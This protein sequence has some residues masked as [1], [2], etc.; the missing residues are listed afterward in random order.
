[1]RAIQVTIA[2]VLIV[3]A[4]A[5]IG[6]LGWSSYQHAQTPVALS[7]PVT[8]A[9]PS[10]ANSAAGAI[11]EA[12]TTPASPASPSPSAAA[13]AEISPT[14][15]VSQAIAP[16]IPAEPTG[17]SAG[18][19]QMAERTVD[20]PEADL[21]VRTGDINNLGFGWPAGFTPFSGKST[22]PHPYPCNPRPGAPAGTDRIMVGTAVTDKDRSTRNSD[23]YVG[24][25]KRPDDLPEAISLAVGDLPPTVHVVLVQMFLDDFQA[26]VWGSH[27]Q[28]SLNGTRIPS[29]ENTINTLRQTGPIGKL[30]T[31]RLLPE[32]LPILKTGTV[33]LLI[34]DPTTHALDGY[35]VD[36]VR[37]LV[38]PHAFKYSVSIACTVVDAA[39]QKPIAGASLSSAQVTESTGTDGMRTLT[40][41]PAGLVSVDAGAVGYDSGVQ[42]VDLEAGAKG[43]LRFELHKHA[44]SGVAELKSSI[45]RNGSVAIYGIHFDTASAALRPDSAKSLQTLLEL[46]KSE[47]GSHWIIAG[48]TDNQGGA[49]YNLSLSNARA[50]SVVAWLGEHGVSADRFQAVGYGATRPIA[51]NATASGRALNRRVEVKPAKP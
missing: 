21:V 40:G 50:K 1:M 12:S 25:S 34:D 41:V 7:T 46:V 31:L 24:C 44:E 20:G 2:V 29:F 35:A 22:P 17:L 4:A 49:D 28:V 18:W 9:E 23:G 30:V 10:S 26:P 5:V 13:S 14:T 42:I 38:N 39:T 19:E 37:I 16:T 51:D 15:S 27:F 32:Y 36:F 47:P 11:P 43:T 6:W 3:G 8:S 45:A 33:N 48:H